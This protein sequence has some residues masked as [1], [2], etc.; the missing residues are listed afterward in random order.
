[1]SLFKSP[2]KQHNCEE[3]MAEFLEVTQH[4][5]RNSERDPKID[6]IIALL[7][8]LPTEDAVRTFVSLI[9]SGN[10]DLVVERL[11]EIEKTA[12]QQ[13]AEALATFRRKNSHY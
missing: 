2:K 3:T 7:P 13:A 8:S 6:R 4:L 12:S 10:H 5:K 11:R 1:M 9:D